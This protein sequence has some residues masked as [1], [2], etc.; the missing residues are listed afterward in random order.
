MEI[1]KKQFKKLFE[2]M[3][4]DDVSSNLLRGEFMEHFDNNRIF[5]FPPKLLNVKKHFPF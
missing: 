2:K 5:D 3:S 1:L 4:Q